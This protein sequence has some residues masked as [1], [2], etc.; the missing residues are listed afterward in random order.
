MLQLQAILIPL[1]QACSGGS[2]GGGGG[3]NEGTEHPSVASAASASATSAPVAASASAGASSAHEV[4][5]CTICLDAIEDPVQLRGCKHEFCRQCITSVITAS[6]TESACPL[7]RREIS[8]DSLVEVKVAGAAIDS[9]EGVV[10]WK[11]ED[12]AA[13]LQ[14]TGWA[15][16]SSSAGS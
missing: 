10:T 11:T 15:G 12:A 3:G 16:G 2:V 5:E 7:C 6:A 14:V 4:R 1:R 9:M 13:R 8:L